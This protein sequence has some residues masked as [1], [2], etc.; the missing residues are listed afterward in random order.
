MH[1]FYR[2]VAFL[3]L[4]LLGAQGLY[5][6]FED[7][8]YRL[9]GFEDG[10]SH[11]N[12]FKIQQ[13]GRGFLWVAT[14]RGLNQF[15]GYRFRQYA[16]PV[17]PFNQLE[18]LCI[19]H[20]SL[21]LLSSD[22]QLAG[23]N[24]FSGEISVLN[25]FDKSD[26]PQRLKVRNTLH[27]LGSKRVLVST[28]AEDQTG[29]HL[30]SWTPES[31]LSPLGDV[32]GSQA[33][34]ALCTSEEEIHFG[35]RRGM[36][37]RLRTDGRKIDSLQIES[38][39][40]VQ[41]LQQ[42]A[43]GQLWALLS[44]GSIWKKKRSEERFEYFGSPFPQLP[45]LP[46][47]SL[48]VDRSGDLW[49]GGNGQ[50]WRYA[51]RTGRWYDYFGNIRQ[52][53]RTS[54]TV[55]Q[56]YQDRTGVYWLATD[57]GLI[58]MVKSANRF[59]K[60]LSGG[61][62]NCSDGFC[63]TRGMTEDEQGRIYVSYYN[64]LHVID[65]ERDLV[66]PL[67]RLQPFFNYPF[68]L[69][70]HKKALWTGNGRR[71]DLETLEVDTLWAD[72]PLDK[73]CLMVDHG[74]I[75]W[76][77]YRNHLYLY[78]PDRRQ[79]DTFAD[80]TGRLDTTVEF[81]FLLRGRQ[82]SVVWAGTEGHGIFRIHRSRGITD[83]YSSE[84]PEG[85]R[86]RT[87]RIIALYEDRQRQLWA[88]TAGGLSCLD[89]MENT[90][91]TYT[92]DDGLP[93][94]F[95][96]GILPEGD[97]CLWISTDYGLSRLNK[98]RKQFVNFFQEDGLTD[99]EFNR[100]SFLKARDGRLYFGGL[101]GVNAFYPGPELLRSSESSEGDLMLTSFYYLDGE[102]D[103]LITYIG[104]DPRLRR[105]E[106]DYQDR[107]FGFE[108]ALSD[109]RSPR[110]NSYSYMLEGFD[111]GWSDWSNITTARYH[112]IPAGDYTFRVRAISL[113]GTQVEEELT[114]PLNIA[115]AFYR[116]PWFIASCLLLALLLL[117]G[118]YRLRLYRIRKHERELETEVQVRTRELAEEKRKS[119]ELLLNILP[120][121]VAEELKQH[122]KSKARRHD[123]V[124]VMF[125]DF[126][127]FTTIAEQMPPE[128]LVHEIDYC[129]RHFDKIIEKYG[130]EKI[131]TIGDAY[132]CVGGI[133]GSSEEVAVKVVRAAL[134][135]QEFL[136]ITGEEK[137]KEGRP[138]FEARIGIHT[139]PVVA[140]IVGI[141]KFAYDIWGDT[142]NIASRVEHNSLPGKVNVSA[143]TYEL[144]KHV[145][146]CTYRGK[147]TAKNKGEIEMWFVEG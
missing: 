50:F 37:Y 3:F 126:K 51:Q 111:Q 26:R 105:M 74:G 24:T 137:E 30:Y 141:K 82:D 124:T 11:R 121:K 63:S 4:T 15:D 17:I 81:N 130:L 84:G 38:G 103:S 71:I 112:N 128:E 13:D 123:P 113:N 5:G 35:G 45:D 83:R 33:R 68:G 61:H 78:D 67:F 10:L 27:P 36:I 49:I 98:D 117:Y 7:V 79:L 70:Y 6:Q 23:F 40:T 52:L 129:F 62:E 118:L 119:D 25:T 87:D 94:D 1:R 29:Q 19:L 89:L 47:T 20:D 42:D 34:Q 48:L 100:I 53:T 90:I 66:Y 102:R 73:G 56:I 43:Q 140:G 135:F 9:Y 106:L 69:L 64:S 142:V 115:Q 28:W 125:S 93:N 14:L 131:K 18:D 72:P 139:G 8:D 39:F 57:F 65:P 116:E 46:P 147:I 54:P 143:G 146:P 92:A 133:S 114:L 16:D 86:L 120:P 22:N 107:L 145:F 80:P 60:Y 2:K 132:M 12:V 122:G 144:I 110:R 32:E 109:F 85:Q 88:A 41:A 75:L 99:N 138:Y 95:I 134:E 44:D 91:N 58:K 97:S 104:G 77:G 127:A 136:K 101:N 31:G 76:F 108:F 21:I 59:R 96:N 55:K